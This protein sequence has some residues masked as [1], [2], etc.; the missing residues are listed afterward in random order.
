MTSVESRVPT[1]RPLDRKL[2]L[3]K[4]VVV[5]DHGPRV[6][7]DA[8]PLNIRSIIGSRCMTGDVTQLLQQWRDGSPEALDELIPYIYGELHQ[9]A[10]NVL[11][12]ERTGHTLQPTALV[13][14]VV[15]AARRQKHSG[16]SKPPSFL[17]RGRAADAANPGGPRAPPSFEKA[18]R[19][20]S[21]HRARW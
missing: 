2:R 15:S 3:A 19:G 14:E 20:S 18:R 13:N 7:A 21:P 5:A 1:A 12:H 6:P 11:R 10:R 9:L 17:P 4:T 16:P 8:T